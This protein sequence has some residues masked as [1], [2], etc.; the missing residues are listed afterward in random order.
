MQ[1]ATKEKLETE[2]NMKVARTA[3]NEA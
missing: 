1:K 2:E 3:W